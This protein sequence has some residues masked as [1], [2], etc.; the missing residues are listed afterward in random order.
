ME[1][2]LPPID[3]HPNTPRGPAYDNLYSL[4]E[5]A[6]DA[7][8]AA[9]PAD[10]AHGKYK[11]LIIDTAD[12]ATK[13]WP[14]ADTTMPMSQIVFVGMQALSTPFAQSLKQ[15]IEDLTLMKLLLAHE[16]FHLSQGVRIRA[17]GGSRDS[18]NSG[19]AQSRER[20]MGYK[21]KEAAKSLA[22]AFP[23]RAQMPQSVKRAADVVS[24]LR[25]DIRALNFAQDRKNPIPGLGAALL[26][27]RAADE[28][29]DPVNAY[30][31]SASMAA[32]LANGLPGERDSVPM[33]WSE[34]FALLQASN[35]EPSLAAQVAAAAKRVKF[36]P[37]S[38][39]ANILKPRL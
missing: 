7:L 28:A 31:T 11:I 10:P 3:P 8:A 12:V 26:A 18:H 37:L 34:A 32:I 38:R 17:C 23:I 9:W 4:I 25:A 35:L 19:F 6:R 15:T 1:T 29:L 24:E 33:L 20:D 16:T 39:V 36:T 2:Y 30:Q 27:A 13:T 22:G 5:S 21:W 14:P